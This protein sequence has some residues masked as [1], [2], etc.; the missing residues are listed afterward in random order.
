MNELLAP[1]DPLPLECDGLTRVLATVLAREGIAHRCYMGSVVDSRTQN[2]SRLHFW[3]ELPDGRTIDY[4]ARMSM[5][6]TEDIPHGIFNK[7]DYPH[8]FYFGHNITLEPLSPILFEAL[9][10]PNPF[11]DFLTQLPSED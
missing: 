7:S 1:Y 9:T 11:A 3:I 5:G 6:E 8:I 2:G 10:M 4:R